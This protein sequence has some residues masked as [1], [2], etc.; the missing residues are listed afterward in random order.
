MDNKK[1]GNFIA[2]KRKELGYSQ[3]DLAEKLN[4]TDKAVSKWETGR[5]TPDVSILISLANLLGVSV[6]ELLNGEEI[7]REEINAAADELI[8]K[9]LESE[10]TGTL[11]VSIV[12]YILTAVHYIIGRI[13]AFGEYVI[14]EE[15]LPEPIWDVLEHVYYKEG[16]GIKFLLAMLILL[17]LSVVIVSACGKE[18]SR[19]SLALASSLIIPPLLYIMSHYF[20]DE[21]PVFILST[22]I[23]CIIHTIA[24]TVFLIKDARKYYE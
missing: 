4:I 23:V 16:G 7:S 2:E 6:T 17:I 8:V 5:S 11:G 19:T 24:T 14:Y 22:I 18:L 1:I 13:Y 3:K 12:I 9:S 10:R 21:N 15:F 20:G